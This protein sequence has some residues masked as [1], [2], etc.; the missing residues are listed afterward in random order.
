M[1]ILMVLCLEMCSYSMYIFVARLENIRGVNELYCRRFSRDKCDRLSPENRSGVP[2]SWERTFGARATQ[3]PND[4]TTRF[5][6]FKQF[7]AKILDVRNNG[8]YHR[9]KNLN[10]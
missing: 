5:S 2:S 10:Q 8:I 1:H 4:L 9:E 6:S 7:L 3:N